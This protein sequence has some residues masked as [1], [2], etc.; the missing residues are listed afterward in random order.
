VF[1]DAYREASSV[2]TT[3]SYLKGRAI[4][5]Y[6]FAARNLEEALAR[7]WLDRFDEKCFLS[8]TAA[9][10]DSPNHLLFGSGGA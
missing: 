3:A 1:A 5:E 7:S 2:K 4:H 6:R 10:S 9:R 8:A